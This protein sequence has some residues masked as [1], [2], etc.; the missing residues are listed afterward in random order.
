MDSVSSI[1]R[2]R[3]TSLKAE[4]TYDL[5]QNFKDEEFDER[6]RQTYD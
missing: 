6:D 2:L 4:K 1:N 3:E 5:L